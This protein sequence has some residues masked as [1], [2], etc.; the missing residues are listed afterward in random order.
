MICLDIL[1]K[2][3]RNLAQTQNTTILFVTYLPKHI[4]DG[5]SNNIIILSDVCFFKLSL[6]V[7]YGFIELIYNFYF[8]LF[9]SLSL[10]L[11]VSLALSLDLSLCLLI[12]VSVSLYICFCVFLYLSLCL[13]MSVPVY[14]YICI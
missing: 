11:S 8:Y 9:L 13:S 12:S 1:A 4:S 10:F 14:L 6:S 5:F 2:T 7:N 3:S